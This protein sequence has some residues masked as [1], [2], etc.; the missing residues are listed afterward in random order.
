MQIIKYFKSKF[1][2]KRHFKNFYLGIDKISKKLD[3]MIKLNHKLILKNN[4]A[5]RKRISNFSLPKRFGTG[6]T[7][8][9]LTLVAIILLVSC[10]KDVLPEPVVTS[11]VISTT[12][13]TAVTMTT[14]VA[15]GNISSDG[16][17]KVTDRGICWGLT[18]NPSIS[19]NKLANGSGTGIFSSTLSG[20]IPGTSYHARAYAVTSLG[21][22]YGNDV[23]F[24][25]TPIMYTVTLTSGPN[26]T[27]TTSKEVASGTAVEVKTVPNIGY[28]T[29]S[30]K[31]DG[32]SFVLN[33]T[34]SYTIMNVTKDL[35]IYVTFKPDP[36]WVLSQNGAW[37]TVLEQRRIPNTISW[38]NFYPSNKILI[39]K[40]EFYQSGNDFKIK[41]NWPDVG[42]NVYEYVVTFKGDSI[43]WGTKPDGT[44]GERM[45]ITHL[46]PQSLVLKTVVK[47]YD[48][49]G[50]RVPEKD[51]DAQYSFEHT[52][53]YK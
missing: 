48:F 17:A 11:P 5:M 40:Y 6:L 13:A 21:T 47:Y 31:V 51:Y 16:G 12:E 45:Q 15:G 2:L 27:A 49:D 25:T 32:K 3:N 14:V 36:K 10:G 20:L 7:G 1:I 18:N 43:I 19:D 9:V 33:G 30:L 34:N 44:M 42:T 24:M 53:S 39:E 4:K 41:V 8:F 26:G 38:F 46:D 52:R 28:I 23:S 29:D 22:F 50:K 37:Y 35:S